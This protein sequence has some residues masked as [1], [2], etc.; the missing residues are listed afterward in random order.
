[1]S[2]QKRG[3]YSAHSNL[4]AVNF[5]CHSPEAKSASVVG[6]FNRWHP[7]SHP[8]TRSPDGA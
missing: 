3:M 5:V 4:R 6:D 2:I 8:M 1:M 7:T